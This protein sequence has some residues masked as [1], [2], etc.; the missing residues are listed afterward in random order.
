MALGSE[1]L[2]MPQKK[3][4]K[5]G[6]P[7]L[8]AAVF[9]ERVL[10]DSD[11]SI[12]AI[13][14]IDGQRM[15]IPADVPPEVPSPDQLLPVQLRIL[16][17]FRSGDSPGKHQLKLMV[18]DPDGKRGEAMAQEV[19]LSQE[20]H[21]GI[22]VK[23]DAI[24]GVYKSGLYLMDVYLDGKRFTR[25]PMNILIERA[26]APAIPEESTSQAK[27]SSRSRK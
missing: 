11:K 4:K 12:S 25:M 18:E 20:P 2:A 1:E 16:L 3:K 23:S 5:I 15:V 8:A 27:S 17:I 14:I 9:C 7:F 21:G 19:D 24:M 13:R 10:D 26:T 6:G 22:N